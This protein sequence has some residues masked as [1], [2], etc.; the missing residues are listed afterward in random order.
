MVL[1]RMD[2]IRQCT[3]FRLQGCIASGQW[4]TLGVVCWLSLDEV[5]SGS[6]F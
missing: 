5:S 4:Q 6:D 3:E 2:E 1:E